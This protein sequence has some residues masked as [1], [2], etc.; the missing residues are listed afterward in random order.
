MVEIRLIVRG[1]DLF[2]KKQA[3]SFEEAT[4]QAWKP[5]KAVDQTQGKLRDCNKIEPIS[6]LSF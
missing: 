4:D 1:Y 3:K 5:Q 6:F 2:A